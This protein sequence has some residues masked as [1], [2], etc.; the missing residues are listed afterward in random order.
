MAD[1]RQFAEGETDSSR[2]LAAGAFLA[3]GGVIV[4]IGT[5]QRWTITWGLTGEGFPETGV[6]TGTGKLV[7]VLTTF[8]NA[9]FGGE[10]A[11]PAAGLGLTLLG[12][13]IAGIGVIVDMTG[14]RSSKRD[15][16]SALR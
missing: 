7:L 5:F 9:V 6:V 8:P 15:S 13:L 14:S 4:A 2:G 10:S 12:T 11:Q 3:C 1:P 16:P